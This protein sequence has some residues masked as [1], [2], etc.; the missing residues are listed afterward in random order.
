MIR[1]FDVAD[2]ASIETRVSAWVSGCEPLMEVFRLNRDAYLDFA[3]KMTGIPYESLERDIKSSDKDKK[4]AAKRHRQIAKPGV[5]GCVYQLG[6]GDLGKNRYGDIVKKGLWGYSEAMGVEMT[7]EQA[8]AI[9]RIFRESYREIPEMWYA[10]ERAVA[11]V[12]EEGTTR[13]KR[14]LGPA[15]CIRID[16]V[17]FSDSAE[18]RFILRIHLPSGRCLH[19]VDAEMQEVKMPWLDQAGQ[20]V[21]RKTLTYSGLDQETKV[22]KR[23]ITSRGGKLFENVVQAIA[24]DILAVKMLRFEEVGMEVIAHV[25]DEAVCESVDCVFQPGYEDMVSIMSEPVS[26]AKNLC[27]GA[28]GFAGA[29]YH[30]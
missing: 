8:H 17:P 24:R 11:D 6:G 18:N 1:R 14:Q 12:L 29:Y 27:L 7:K 19:Y 5:L 9:V 30:K 15:G 22:W 23:G 4:S 25:H 16:K 26:W 20:E 21:Y 3:V 28:D 10:L 2:L 13:V